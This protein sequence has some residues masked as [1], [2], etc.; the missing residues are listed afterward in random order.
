MR[1]DWDAERDVPAWP[2]RLRMRGFD[3]L[4]FAVV[5][6]VWWVLTRSRMI[7]PVFLPSPEATLR[8]FLSLLNVSFFRD[9]FAPSFLRVGGAFLL[10]AAIAVPLGVLSATVSKVRRMV[11]PLCS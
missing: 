10:S 6:A 8:T 2:V 11:L 9:N 5:V 3:V 4:P 1:D 7:N